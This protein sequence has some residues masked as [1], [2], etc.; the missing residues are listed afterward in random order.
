MLS[1]SRFNNLTWQ[2]N[3]KYR[4]KNKMTGPIYGVPMKMRE[5]VMID[6]LV[7]IIE[8]N[9]ERNRIEGIGL[10]KNRS[11]PT[12]E[13]FAFCVYKSDGNFNRYIYK[14]D[15]RID[16]DI[17]QS[18]NVKLVEI[19][20]YICF[21]GKTHLKRGNGFMRI[22]D[23]LLKNHDIIILDIIKDIFLKHFSSEKKEN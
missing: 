12:E 5:T 21:K 13:R 9:N 23:K 4:E 3:C 1:T 10:I 16:R 7:F 14:G 6:T 19:L 20:D 17:L 15:Y 22:P 18:Y 8:M 11:I 2:E